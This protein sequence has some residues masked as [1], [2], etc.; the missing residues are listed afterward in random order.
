IL[1][2]LLA[3]KGV[4]V[5]VMFRQMEHRGIKVTFRSQGAQDVGLLA[6]RLGGGGRRTA[7]GAPLPVPMPSAIEEVLPKV[8]ALREGP[9]ASRSRPNGT[10]RDPSWRR[11]ASESRPDCPDRDA[12]PRIYCAIVRRSIRS[13]RAWQSIT[14]SRTV[15]PPW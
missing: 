9:A 12:R 8:R 10:G 15:P 4:E 6:E 3:L 1:D 2:Q 5:C 7:S 13:P 14:T 11:A